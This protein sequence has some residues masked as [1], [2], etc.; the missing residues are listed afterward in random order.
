[1]YRI[2]PLCFVAIAWAGLATPRLEAF[3]ARMQF[4]TDAVTRAEVGVPYL[5]HARAV[6][7]ATGAVTYRLTTAPD[8][9]T[10]DESTGTVSWPSPAVGS[11]NVILKATADLGLLGR[12]EAVQNY[13]VKVV[14]HRDSVHPRCAWLQ[15]SVQLRGSGA[16]VADGLIQAWRV[17]SVSN[18][19][20]ADYAAV[21]TSV[22]SNGRFAM[23]VPSGT[24]ILRASATGQ[25]RFATTF[26]AADS[27]ASLTAQTAERIRV[28][29]S[30][31]ARIV[32]H[33]NPVPHAD[34]TVVSGRVVDMETEAG[35]MATVTFTRVG[36]RVLQMGSDTI[37]LGSARFTASTNAD[38]TFQI[39]LP[40]GTYM[41]MAKADAAVNGNIAYHPQFFDQQSDAT[42]AR[43][44]AV[45]SIEGEMVF[46]LKRAGQPDTTGSISGR[47]ISR[48]SAA[49]TGMISAFRADSSGAPFLLA[50][51]SAEIETDGS[52]TIGALPPGQYILCIRPDSEA[53]IGG[54]VNLN[55]GTT[56]H[57]EHASRIAVSAAANVTA[58]V[59][60]RSAA[61][62][63][64]F[65]CITGSVVT[66]VSG[67][68]D[69]AVQG[70]LVTCT[71]AY[72]QVTATTFTDS[73]GAFSLDLLQIGEYTVVVDRVGLSSSSRT[74]VI[75][76]AN[77]APSQNFTMDRVTSVQTRDGSTPTMVLRPN[78][79]VSDVVVELDVV[80]GMIQVD[81]ITSTGSIATTLTSWTSTSGPLQ[82]DLP[83]NLPSGWYLVRLQNGGRV[84]TRQLIMQR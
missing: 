31:T 1:M 75:T 59:V 81:V 84:S 13:F 42:C 21:Y 80:P 23:T 29:C 12:V 30:D 56:A 33:V 36:H 65:A 15:G 16:A 67:A 55:G 53:W 71:N 41:A 48:T 37:R 26:H 3:E 24:Y 66:A 68:T 17:A 4:I 35:L 77:T 74:V 63:R 10:C 47:V 9:M 79:A 34:T 8:G 54:Y 60:A 28:E 64:G 58:T 72:G 32:F 39:E 52:F 38:G 82:I 73:E 50:A 49:I 78:P 57:W 25:A 22:I 46:R 20:F 62:V 76:E 2:I 14:Q 45:A 5:Y 27:M 51:A 44:F 69:A 6:A 40:Q 61:T 83:L 19:G 18:T 70:A 43:V 11:H 7:S